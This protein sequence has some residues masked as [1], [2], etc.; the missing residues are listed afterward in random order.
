MWLSVD[1][2]ADE[3]P[4]LTPYA[5]VLNNPIGNIDP[6]GRDVVILIAP[7]GAGGWGHMAM[8]IQDGKGNWFYY[9]QGAAEAAGVSKMA[10]QGVHGG[11]NLVPLNTTDINTAIAMAKTDDNNS[12]YQDQIVLETSQKMDESIYNNAVRLM[13]ETN[14][15]EKKYNVLTNNCVD[16]CQDPIELG[17]GIDLPMD[18]NPSPNAYFNKIKEQLSDI[19]ANLNNKINLEK[20]EVKLI[21]NT[22]T[23]RDNTRVIQNLENQRLKE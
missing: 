6:D 10:S 1:P 12:P 22:S 20:R 23:L 8:I 4:S 19:Q 5:F 18:L 9:T 13:N 15:G 21:P 17:T 7:Q 14:S 16:A 3:Y 2:A 11:V